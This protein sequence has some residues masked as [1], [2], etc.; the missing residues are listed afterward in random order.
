MGETEASKA[1]LVSPK[2]LEL[3]VSSGL[4][5]PSGPCRLHP[6]PPAATD[7]PMSMLA[8]WSRTSLASSAD[9]TSVSIMATA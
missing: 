6:T 4:H 3:A 9:V 1:K 2:R 8:R 7:P 5:K